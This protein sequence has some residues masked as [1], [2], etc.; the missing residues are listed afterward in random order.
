MMMMMSP[1]DLF[2]L[3]TRILEDLSKIVAT[4]TLAACEGELNMSTSYGCT[5]CTGSCENS[6]SSGCSGTCVGGYGCMT[7]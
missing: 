7:Q 2:S 4:P 3:P 6:C 1:K 5:D